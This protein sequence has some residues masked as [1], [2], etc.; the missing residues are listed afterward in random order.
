[1]KELR[2]VSMRIIF[3]RKDQ[4]RKMRNGHWHPWE[5]SGKMLGEWLSGKRGAKAVKLAMQY[6]WCEGGVI[7]NAGALVA[8]NS[9]WQGHDA[10]LKRYPDV[11]GEDVKRRWEEMGILLQ[12]GEN[13]TQAV[14]DTVLLA[15]LVS[16]FS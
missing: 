16:L 12:D 8:H 7:T 6:I 3:V 5:N 15:M 9:S 10:F 2:L 14:Y 11:V 4:W 13:K 1:M